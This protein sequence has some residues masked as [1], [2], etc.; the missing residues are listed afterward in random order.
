MGKNT[1][2]I[3]KLRKKTNARLEDKIPE[4]AKTEIKVAY[5]AYLQHMSEA[6][7]LAASTIIALVPILLAFAAFSYT[8]WTDRGIEAQLTIGFFGVIVVLGAG[9]ALYGVDAGRYDAAAAAVLR[10]RIEKR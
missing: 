8:L 4:G 6:K 10:H 5:A 9:F 2:N 7:R 3:D 1:V